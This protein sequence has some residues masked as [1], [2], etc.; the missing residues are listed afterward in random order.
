VKTF[1][2][3]TLLACIAAL[4]L[5]LETAQAAA[6]EPRIE[7]CLRAAAQYQRLPYE[8]LKAVARVESSFNPRAVNKL[9]RNGTEDIGL[10][11][12]NSA[13]LPLLRSYGITR[14]SLFDPC[15]N[16]HVGAWILAQNVARFGYTVQAV[17]AYNAGPNGKASTKIA[18]ARKVIDHYQAYLREGNS[19]LIAMR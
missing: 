8:L 1:L 9:N 11:Q 2:K 6:P 3:S 16:A 12:I 5:G 4:T 10:M 7:A 13:W 17:G 18:Y 15:T 19:Q 14:A